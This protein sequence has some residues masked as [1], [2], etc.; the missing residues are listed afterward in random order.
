MTLLEPARQYAKARPQREFQNIATATEVGFAIMGF[1]SF[2]VTLIHT[3]INYVIVDR[4][5][6]TGVL[7]L[8]RCRH[9]WS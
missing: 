4:L 7:P 8:K 2:F 1:I 6:S 3:P 9:S 5:R